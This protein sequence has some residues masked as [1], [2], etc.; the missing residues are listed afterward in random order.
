[1]HFREIA[2]EPQLTHN[3][4]MILGK[5]NLSKQSDITAPPLFHTTHSACRSWSPQVR[6]R[7]NSHNPVASEASAKEKVQNKQVK[8]SG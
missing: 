8:T 1:M 3:S 6:E 5:W 7:S 2:C 4:G